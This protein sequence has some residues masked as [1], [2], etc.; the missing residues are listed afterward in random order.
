MIISKAKIIQIQIPYQS[1]LST[2]R[3]PGSLFKHA[4][5][6]Y[7]TTSEGRSIYS[8]CVAFP[9]PLYWPETIQ[10]AHYSLSKWLLPRLLGVSLDS[11]SHASSIMDA[12]VRGHEM[13]KGCIEMGVSALWAADQSLAQF[14]GSTQSQV[15][16]GYVIGHIP[17]DQELVS[18]IQ[19]GLSQGYCSFKFKLCPGDEDRLSRLIT[20]TIP[21]YVRVSL[22]ANG[23]YQPNDI[24]DLSQVNWDRISQFEQPFSWQDLSSHQV[25]ARQIPATILLDESLRAWQQVP[26]LSTGN[27]L[28]GLSIK[29][30]RLGG[31]GPAKMVLDQAKKLGVSCRLGGMMETGIGRAYALAFS[32]LDGIDLGSDL[33]ASARYFERD[34]LQDPIQVTDDGYLN[35]PDQ[36]GIGVKVDED[37]LAFLE[38]ESEELYAE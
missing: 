14:L 31:Y 24:G 19:L 34:V 30:G 21:E 27:P 18:T 15:E 7:L 32:G 2:S 11:V 28:L 16:A 36:G 22:D 12:H 4:L 13:A 9:D 37:Y 35:I 33:S 6:L 20:E 38:V 10:M 8:E 29:P 23:A 26:L 1:V 3:G 17:D 25:L 5:L